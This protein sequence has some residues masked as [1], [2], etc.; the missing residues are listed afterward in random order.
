[1]YYRSLSPASFP[2]LYFAKVKNT[3]KIITFASK[4]SPYVRLSSDK[5]EFRF[6]TDFIT[7]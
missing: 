4:L 2:I 7:L 5:P 1:M 3:L 6:T